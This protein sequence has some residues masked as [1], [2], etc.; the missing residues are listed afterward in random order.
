MCGPL[1]RSAV[2]GVQVHLSISFLPTVDANVTEPLCRSS[3]KGVRL[4]TNKIMSRPVVT[5]NGENLDDV[6]AQSRTQHSCLMRLDEFMFC[7][8]V[9]NQF[10]TYYRDGTYSD[11]PKLF[12]RWQRCLKSK[13]SKEEVAAEI[14]RIDRRS[15]PREH[16][17]T[18]RPQYAAEA[19]E[20]YGIP[21]VSADGA[22]SS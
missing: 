5:I 3:P 12:E 1:D 20:R 15:L 2:R 13:L 22:A 9:T 6:L 7:M 11:C 8:S 10:A 17:F 18:F 16:I 19:H 14:M 4:R 21:L